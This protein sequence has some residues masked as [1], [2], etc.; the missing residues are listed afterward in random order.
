MFLGRSIH[1]EPHNLFSNSVSYDV[2]IKCYFPGALCQEDSEIFASIRFSGPNPISA[3]TKTQ[4]FRQS[5]KMFVLPDCISDTKLKAAK[6]NKGKMFE[7][8]VTIEIKTDKRKRHESKLP[9]ALMRVSLEH[10]EYMSEH[11]MSPHLPSTKGVTSPNAVIALSALY[12]LLSEETMRLSTGQMWYKM[13][14]Y[15]TGIISRYW[16]KDTASTGTGT[17]PRDLREF[18]NDSGLLDHVIFL[19]TADFSQGSWSA[20]VPCLFVG[21]LTFR[22]N[23]LNKFEVLLFNDKVLKTSRLL[24]DKVKERK[25]GTRLISRVVLDALP[26]LYNTTEGDDTIV[27]FVHCLADLNHYYN[28]KNTLLL[29]GRTDNLQLVESYRAVN[30][31][32][33][34]VSNFYEFYHK[35]ALSIITSNKLQALPIGTAQLFLRTI[36]ENKINPYFDA[37]S[38]AFTLNNITRLVSKHASSQ[39][40]GFWVKWLKDNANCNPLLF[41][42]VPAEVSY[43]VPFT[44]DCGC[45]E[46]TYQ[47]EKVE[48]GKL[49]PLYHSIYTKYWDMVV[50]P[51]NAVKNALR[52]GGSRQSVR[53]DINKI[54]Q[55]KIRGNSFHKNKEFQLA[56]VE[57]DKAIDMLMDLK[58]K[59]HGEYDDNPEVQYDIE[60][61]LTNCRSNRVSSNLELSRNEDAIVDATLA[62]RELRCLLEGTEQDYW[63]IIE[64]RKD[65]DTL[66]RRDTKV[67]FQRVKALVNLKQWGP[68]LQNILIVIRHEQFKELAT[69]YYYE[70]LTRYIQ[71]YKNMQYPPF[72]VVCCTSEEE[73]DKTYHELQYRCKKCKHPYCSTECKKKDAPSHI[74][75]CNNLTKLYQS[76]VKSK[77]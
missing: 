38:Q 17:S 22:A 57:Y 30:T 50:K 58:L 11:M 42:L 48:I 75:Y 41:D 34:V 18:M 40:V 65:E 68:A 62:L 44:A 32:N 28:I 16:W 33:T 72:C 10:W 45:L 59:C 54:D 3:V 1:L 47:N 67:R 9:P 20:L 49:M 60:N 4:Y 69:G 77:M 39:L 7:F 14:D 12:N 2:V 52:Y 29:A 13:L 43:E 5:Q 66:T 23:T 31:A 8:A 61:L 56:L 71:H 36:G 73:D 76:L 15:V 27:Q 64:E 21:L 46:V 26:M 63:D 70:C 19:L 37:G 55:V 24:M 51:L 53:N 35:M 74:K 6:T 25:Y